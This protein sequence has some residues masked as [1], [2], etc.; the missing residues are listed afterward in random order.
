MPLYN[1]GVRGG[2]G[3]RMNC[4]GVG[5]R[6]ISIWHWWCLFISVKMENIQN[7]RETGKC[8]LVGVL[9]SVYVCVGVCVYCIIFCSFSPCCCCCCLS[10]LSFVLLCFGSPETLTA[11]AAEAAYRGCLIIILQLASWLLLSGLWFHFL[12]RLRQVWLIWKRDWLPIEMPVGESVSG[13]ACC[14]NF[15]PFLGA[16]VVASA[17][18]F[19]FNFFLTLFGLPFCQFLFVWPCENI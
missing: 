4:G 16:P 10:R 7:A 17:S 9:L 12:P 1:E 14:R 13:F 5:V 18:L 8:V 3:R 6:V 2:G 11:A 19:L 15:L